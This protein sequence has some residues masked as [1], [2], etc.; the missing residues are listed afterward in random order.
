MRARTTLWGPKWD[1]PKKNNE[2]SFSFRVIQNFER[3]LFYLS[4]YDSFIKDQRKLDQKELASFHLPTS[5]QHHPQNS[6][7]AT[8]PSRLGVA[9]PTLFASCSK[10]FLDRCTFFGLRMKNSFSAVKV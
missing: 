5:S 3:G 6:Y 7:V 4:A 9:V 1:G 2:P 10:T 8:E